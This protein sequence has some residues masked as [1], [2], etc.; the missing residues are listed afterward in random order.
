MENTPS[1][2]H[3]QG[4]AQTCMCVL[5]RREIASTCTVF[6]QEHT[7]PSLQC[8]LN[9]LADSGLTPVAPG[10]AHSGPSQSAASVTMLHSMTARAASFC[11]QAPCRCPSSPVPSIDRFSSTS[12]LWSGSSTSQCTSF[13]NSIMSGDKH[14]TARHVRGAVDCSQHLT[15]KLVPSGLAT[16]KLASQKMQNAS[17][18]RAMHDSSSSWTNRSP[19]F[20]DKAAPALQH[21]MGAVSD[22]SMVQGEIEASVQ[23]VDIRKTPA[24]LQGAGT[25]GRG[26]TEVLAVSVVTKQGTCSATYVANLTFLQHVPLLQ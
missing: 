19:P 5:Q 24:D 20:K 1:A 10:L 26:R 23:E 12:S 16:S 22:A 3:V 4:V 14:D 13:H 8:R 9:L 15:P 2:Q 7:N 21:V 17:A 25:L 6:D 11:K 18:M